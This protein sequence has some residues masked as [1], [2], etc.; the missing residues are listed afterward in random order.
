MPIFQDDICHV[1][2][3]SSP[4]GI[5]PAAAR[6]RRLSEESLRTEL[7]EGPV[8]DSPMHLS[9]PKADEE[10]GISDRAEL[11]QRL[12]RGESPTWIPG[13]HLESILQQENTHNAQEQGRASPE[14]PNLLPPATITPE[15]LKSPANVDARLRDGLDIERPRSAFHSGDFTSDGTAPENR[16]HNGPG[17][18]AREERGP[19]EHG[20]FTTSPPRHFTPF[21]YGGRAHGGRARLME[22]DGVDGFKSD[23][24]PLST[25][26]SSFVYQPPTSPLAQS[27]SN[28]DVDFS[29]PP[30]F[31]SARHKPGRLTSSLS[32]SSL[33]S[34]SARTRLH[35]LHSSRREGALP[36]QA[37]QPRRSLTSAPSFGHNH[38]TVSSPQTPAFMRSRRQSF[39]SDTSPIQHASMV[40]SYEESI[41]RGRMSTTPSKPFEFLAQIGVLGKGNCKPSLRCPRHVT[42]PFPAVYYSYGSASHGRSPSDDGPSPY[43]G[44]IDLENGLSNQ[45]EDSRSRRKA[46]SRYSDM[47]QQAGGEAAGQEA[48]TD[49]DREGRRP[50]RLKRP[51]GAPRAPPG[52]SYRIPE[53]GQIQIVIKNPNKTAVKLF[54]VPYDLTGMMP[55]TKTF[56]RQRSYSAGPIIDNVPNMSQ[57]DADRPILRYLVHLHICCP[58]KGRFYLYKS[59]RVVFANRVPDGKEKLRNET[60]WPEPRFSPYKAIRVMNPP[61]STSGGAGAMLAN[62]KALRR[63]SLGVFMSGNMSTFDGMD[64]TPSPDRMLMAA[65]SPSP[66]RG[67]VIPVEMIPLRLP[68]SI[69]AENKDGGSSSQANTGPSTVDSRSGGTW[70]PSQYEKLNRGDAGYGGNAFG[71]SGA[72]SPPGTA[73]E[74][75]LSQRL[76]SL[77]VKP[78]QTPE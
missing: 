72:A 14:S 32:A 26:L 30:G 20:W 36:Y 25:S 46:Q 55:G 66:G 58:A 75:L 44:Q 68:Q 29:T 24:S 6:N 77:G 1:S 27:E 40:G 5:E 50:S 37:H 12:K 42:L 71:R 35:S 41:L 17:R 7:C 22:H 74:S 49:A 21:S 34:S 33:V 54:L 56:I 10:A 51:S 65:P 61:L 13:K 11:I 67:G 16:Q 45:E 64:G 76:R 15:K 23:G 70:G 48:D 53:T 78:Q 59:I 62:E 57:A 28:E 38:H 18:D 8:P 47:K 73:P 4:G 2:P 39:G 19:S 43:V 63:R 31:A 9:T 60:T 69:A 3:A 52:G